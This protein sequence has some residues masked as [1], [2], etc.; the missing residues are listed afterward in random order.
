MIRSVMPLAALALL[1][2]GATFLWSWPGGI[3][4]AGIALW[5]EQMTD[6]G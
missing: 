1:T 3:L 4:A 6:G 2:T 5:L